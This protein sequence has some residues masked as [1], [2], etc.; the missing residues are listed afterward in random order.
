MRLNETLI[1]YNDMSSGHHIRV[2]D[3]KPE[4]ARRR[5]FEHRHADFELSYI[6]DGA[7]IHHIRGDQLEIKKGDLFVIGSNQ[8]HCITDNL[9]NSSPLFIL[10][11]QF[12]PKM[13]WSP[14]SNMLPPDYV[15]LFKLKCERVSPD[16][17]S[18]S[19]IVD[20]MLAIYRESIDKRPGYAIMI[21]SYLCEIIALLMRENPI[22]ISP[23]TKRTRESLITMDQVM[24]YINNNLGSSLSLA[25]IAERTGLSRTYFSTLFTSLNGLT[26][27]EYITLKR[28]D[29]SK[30]L[31]TSTQASILEIS[32]LC[33][34]ENLS[35]FNRMFLRITG[36]TPSQ[37][38]K[39]HRHVE[40]V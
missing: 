20:K 19:T 28:I 25:Q 34:Y 31:L 10:N 4:F 30:A 15:N 22:E 23:E 18:Y 40:S 14:L 26:P 9:I 35:N 29:K 24:T 5:Y 1:E 12:E 2:Y 13:I 6:M 32:G 8:I 11:V 21:K 33:G 39:S 38:R 7:G 37:Y 16:C 17:E 3:S 36:E 27:W